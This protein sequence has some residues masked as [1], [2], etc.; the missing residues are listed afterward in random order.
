[1]KPVIA[2]VGRPNVGKSTLFN[3]LTKSREA[4]VVDR[5]G[6]TR[7]RQFGIANINGQDFILVD[8]AGLGEL[9]PDNEVMIKQVEQ[10]SFQAI[11]ESDVII[12]LVDGRAGLS[13][14]DESIAEKL[15]QINKPCFLAVNKTEGMD[16]NIINA[17]FYRLGLGDPYAISAKRAPVLIHC[18]MTWYRF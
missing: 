15:R 3:F 9:N 17:D 4:L 1:M 14:I 12:F 10:Q 6:V 5:P 8:T 16:S 13:T 11:M 2:I 7:D 18:L